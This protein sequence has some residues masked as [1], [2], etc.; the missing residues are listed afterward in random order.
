MSARRSVL[1]SISLWNIKLISLCTNS[2]CICGM[3]APLYTCKAQQTFRVYIT[4]RPYRRSAFQIRTWSEFELGRNDVPHS[5]KDHE[6]PS[7][8]HVLLTRLTFIMNFKQISAEFA[9]TRAELGR[10]LIRGG[11]ICS[12]KWDMSEPSTTDIQLYAR[13]G[14][15]RKG[16]G[17]RRWERK[18]EGGGRGR[19]KEGEGGRGRVKEGEGGRGR[20]KEGEGGRRREGKGEGGEEGEEGRRGR[21]GRV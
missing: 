15:E 18:G 2:E 9:M 3:G 4:D 1:L 11:T 17:G 19:V 5:Y 16:E 13:E 7:A 20:V 21:R 8:A 6:L 14:R 12:A 10:R